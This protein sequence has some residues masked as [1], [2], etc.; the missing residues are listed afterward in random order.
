MHNRLIIVTT[1]SVAAAL[2]A[3][4]TVL[5][6]QNQQPSQIEPQPSQIEPRSQKQ[7]VI[8][9]S[10]DSPPR[11]MAVTATGSSPVCPGSCRARQ[12]E[13]V[14][15]SMMIICAHQA[16][17]D[18]Y[19]LESVTATPSCRC[20]GN[21]DNAYVIKRTESAATPSSTATTATT[22]AEP[23]IGQD[24]PPFRLDN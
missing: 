6:A 12:L 8:V 22:R 23:P 10:E 20:L 24:Q 7:T 15:G 9:C 19:L 17:P 14:V 5:F 18:G 4:G 13:P 16:I 1:F 11:G 3:C 2:L 21:D